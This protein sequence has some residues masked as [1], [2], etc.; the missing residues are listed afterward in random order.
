MLVE[1]GEE[2]ED[3]ALA[4]GDFG[5]DVVAPADKPGDCADE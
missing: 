5:D 1:E 3:V 2:V 4:A